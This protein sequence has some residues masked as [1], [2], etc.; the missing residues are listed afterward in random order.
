MY[1]ADVVSNA[2]DVVS[3]PSMNQG[4]VVPISGLQALAQAL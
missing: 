4:V 2:A 3:L 1:S